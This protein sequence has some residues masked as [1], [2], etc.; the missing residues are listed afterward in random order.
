MDG[1]WA[2]KDTVYRMNL[3][4]PANA[5]E[6]PCDDFRFRQ[7][8]CNSV[9]N[10]FSVWP[11]AEGMRLAFFLQRNFVRE[12]AALEILVDRNQPAR[13]QLSFD[14]LLHGFRRGG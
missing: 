8:I 1:P 7:S 3:E 14:R 6:S 10:D 9:G 5:L 12:F 11:K 2:G 4:R 13:A